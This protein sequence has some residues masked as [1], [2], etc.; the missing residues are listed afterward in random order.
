MQL[1][2]PL[3]SFN[4]NGIR[5]NYKHS[6]ENTT[7]N[8]VNFTIEHYQESGIIFCSAESDKIILKCNFGIGNWQSLLYEDVQQSIKSIYQGNCNSS[9]QRFK[10]GL[11]INQTYS[12]IITVYNYSSIVITENIFSES[13]DYLF[14]INRPKINAFVNYGLVIDNISGRYNFS[15]SRVFF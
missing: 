15:Y 7:S 8:C 2:I 3:I 14:L 11:L 6:I 4:V 5:T 13:L 1:T 10:D 12:N 9:A